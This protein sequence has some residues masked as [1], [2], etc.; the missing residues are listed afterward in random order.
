MTLGGDKGC[1]KQLT[2]EKKPS[3]REIENVGVEVGARLPS[4]LGWSDWASLR[5][6]LKQSLEGGEGNSR[7]IIWKKMVPGRRTS[8][9][10]GLE[11]RA[12]L[13]GLWNSTEA[14]VLGWCKCRA[15]N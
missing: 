14:S 12:G 6:R 8:Q 3:M 7:A 9:H 15:E 13:A 11:A 5:M 1:G 2:N 10:G 4:S